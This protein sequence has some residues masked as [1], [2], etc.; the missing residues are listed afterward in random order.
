MTVEKR[1][2][3]SD[4]CATAFGLLHPEKY[5][6][7]EYRVHENGMSRIAYGVGFKNKNSEVKE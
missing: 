6:D 1:N 4:E 7:R 5:T 2:V 3:C